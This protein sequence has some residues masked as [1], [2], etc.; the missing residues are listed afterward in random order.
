VESERERERERIVTLF[1]K[2]SILHAAA[3]VNGRVNEPTQSFFFLLHRPS[4]LCKCTSCLETRRK[5]NDT[6][7]NFRGRRNKGVM[8]RVFFF[9]GC[10]NENNSFSSYFLSRFFYHLDRGR[11]INKQR[12]LFFFTRDDTP[13]VVKRDE[14]IVREIERDE[15][16]VDV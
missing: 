8:I 9:L 3:K 7:M 16:V 12:K 6:T 13:R 5:T 15:V 10:W 1:L 2:F 4:F 11:S 14:I